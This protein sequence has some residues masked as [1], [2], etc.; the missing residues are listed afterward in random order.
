MLTLF[1]RLCWRKRRTFFRKRKTENSKIKNF[2]LLFLK[3]TFTLYKTVPSLNNFKTLWIQNNTK[4][5]TQLSKANLT[6]SKI[7]RLL[8]CLTKA[9]SFKLKNTHTMLNIFKKPPKYQPLALAF[10]ILLL[11]KCT[12]YKETTLTLLYTTHSFHKK[13]FFKTYSTFFKNTKKTLMKTTLKFSTKI[14][15][16]TF[17]NTTLPTL[18]KCCSPRTK[19]HTK[20]WKI[21]LH[22]YKHLIT[23]LHLPMHSINHSLTPKSTLPYLK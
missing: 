6:T 10:F 19:K 1:P 14:L 15:S 13:T 4:P 3:T 23:F 16:F 20:T 22:F 8:S 12:N 11:L 5:T 17:K 9:S 7:I 2:F 21:Q 18:I